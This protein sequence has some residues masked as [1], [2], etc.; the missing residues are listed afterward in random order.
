MLTDMLGLDRAVWDRVREDFLGDPSGLM[1]F[2]AGY[3]DAWRRRT[4]S[5][6][7]RASPPDGGI[8]SSAS[9]ARATSSVAGGAAYAAAAAAPVAAP[10]LTLYFDPVFRCLAV[11]TLLEACRIPHEQHLVNIMR[12][13][14]WRSPLVDINPL[15]RLP[16]LKARS[17]WVCGVCV[18]A[19]ACLCVCM[20]TRLLANP[21]RL[22][23]LRCV[24]ARSC[25]CVQ[26]SPCLASVAQ[27]IAQLP[28]IVHCT[29]GSNWRCIQ[30]R[31][32]AKG[33]HRLTALA[34]PNCSALHF[35]V[36]GC[37]LCVSWTV[38][39]AP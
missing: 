2:A 28:G 15:G 12:A 24:L 6:A 14:M 8:A 34:N 25:F 3:A 16:A 13:D 39:P 29:S 1:H 23:L 37:W 31:S 38:T 32:S 26:P 36:C 11:W 27:P 7:P 21:M 9:V 19:C 5:A 22:R 4:H 10:S 18:C 33:E 30:P 17:V 35:F 20:V